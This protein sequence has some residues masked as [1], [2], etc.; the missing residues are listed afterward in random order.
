MFR[1]SKNVRYK[2]T[3]VFLG[4][5]LLT[6]IGAI[7][8]AQESKNIWLTKTLRV[9]FQDSTG[10]QSYSG[11]YE[12]DE[13]AIGRLEGSKRNVYAMIGENKD[14]TKFGYCKD[15]RRVS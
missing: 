15:E 1:T 8:Y 6:L 3:I 5:V 2:Y 4:L 10:L 7:I 13:S 14:R 9:E 12:I 11:C